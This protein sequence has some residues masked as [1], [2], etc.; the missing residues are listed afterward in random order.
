MATLCTQVACLDGNS[1]E[2]LN[3]E[4][5]EFLFRMKSFINDA[6]VVTADI[7]G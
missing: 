5:A 4:L 6:R 3:G 7:G 2:M 1:I